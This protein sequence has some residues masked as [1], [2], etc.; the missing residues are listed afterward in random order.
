MFFYDGTCSLANVILISRSGPLAYPCRSCTIF[1]CL[2]IHTNTHKHTNTQTHKHTNTQ[3]HKHTNTQTHTHNPNRRRTAAGGRRPLCYRMCS[4]MIECV[5]LLMP[6]SS[7][8]CRLPQIDDGP[9]PE[10]VDP[11][12]HR[13][14]V[15]AM[16]MLSDWPLRFLDQTFVFMLPCVH[17]TSGLGSAADGN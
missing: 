13:E 6:F 10:G 16:D 14:A 12:Q 7:R 11:E 15:H 5:L 3:T 17:A 4:L 9:P 2:Q 8:A 1:H